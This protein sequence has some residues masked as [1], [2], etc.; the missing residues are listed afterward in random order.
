MRFQDVYF[1]LSLFTTRLLNIDLFS[2]STALTNVRT[3]CVAQ[4]SRRQATCAAL[5]LFPVEVFVAVWF[6]RSETNVNA[7]TRCRVWLQ[8]QLA[9]CSSLFAVNWWCLPGCI[10]SKQLADSA[11]GGIC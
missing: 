5:H 11:T 9:L 6:K 2:V 4:M 7:R 3:K 8:Q 10:C 1:A